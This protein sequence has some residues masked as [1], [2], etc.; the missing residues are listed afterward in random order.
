MNG[1]TTNINYVGCPGV[2]GVEDQTS[3]ICDITAGFSYVLTIDFNSCGSFMGGAGTAWIDWNSNSAFDGSE[4]VGTWTGTPPYTAVFGFMIPIGA[5]NGD[6]RL[7][8]MQQEGATLPLNACGAF[9]FGSVTDFTIN[10][11]GGNCSLGSSSY[12]AGGP[13]T[14]ADSNVGSVSF[15]GNTSNIN[16]T[17]TCP[18]YLG[19]QDETALM[20]DV[21]AGG[22]Y[23]LSVQF[24]TCGGNY[25][26]SGQIWIDFNQNFTFEASESVG[27]W[28]GTPPVPMSNYLVS[29][30]S[31][32]VN[33]TTR[34]RVMQYEGGG[35]PLNPCSVFSWGSV[36]DFTIQITGGISCSGFAGDFLADAIVVPSLPYIDSNSTSIC[37]TS[38]SP[39]YPS[40]DV[41]YKFITDPGSS[42]VKI[43]L[44]NSSFDTYLS[45]LDKN[46]NLIS[47]NDDG[48]CGN[49]AQVILNAL[50]QDTLY[51]V[52]EG[53]NTE[54]G[55]FILTIDDVT[56][57]DEFIS[58]NNITL[59][60]NPANDL[61]TVF[62]TVEMKSVEIFQM[63]GAIITSLNVNGLRKSELS[64]TTFEKGIY[65]VKV[66]D[67][68]GSSVIQKLIIQ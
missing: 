29:I 46:G 43:S 13:T 7:R 63:N 64:L 3:Q 59:F 12:C 36:S 27:T 19:V 61:V 52:V 47:Y 39:V 26:G 51:A 44:C 21:F 54:K 48:I 20:A 66:I 37:Y 1:N 68:N 32:A 50:D 28:T 8:V 17:G 23:S 6:T 5:C 55:D 62:S 57:M 60:P 25:F 65:I 58:L 18:G 14:N 4:I 11:I 67:K 34:M 9:T 40:P 31:D 56:G 16:F 10:I 2:L 22:T 30:P 38:F 53:W 42:S 24:G 49:N 35:L 45:V 41:Y 15:T 33:G